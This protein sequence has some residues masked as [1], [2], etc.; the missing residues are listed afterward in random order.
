MKVI[1]VIL[2]TII[3]LSFVGIALFYLKT[4]DHNISELAI[5]VQAIATVVL[6][7]ITAFY[8]LETRHSRIS[9]EKGF[10]QYVKEI[11]KSRLSQE[12]G[13]QEYVDELQKSRSAQ[14]ENVDKFVYELQEA[15][16]QEIKPH[17]Y[18][19]FYFSQNLGKFF[20]VI[21]NIG[22]GPAFDI[23]ASYT[24]VDNEGKEYKRVYKCPML[25]PEK[26]S[27]DGTVFTMDV[28]KKIDSVTIQISYKDAFKETFTKSYEDIL[29]AEYPVPTEFAE[30]RRRLESEVHHSDIRMW[31]QIF[32]DSIRNIEKE[33]HGI[34]EAIKNK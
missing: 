27:I 28:A 33:L 14:E 22:L 32:N 11:E 15:R 23:E 16:K 17:V 6:V 20:L 2:I 21:M 19:L 30:R 18:G 10:S 29:T 12:K 9:Q 31:V 34:N 1:P 24:A 25:G 7:L 3:I 13:F 5:W 8:A 26:E 4:K